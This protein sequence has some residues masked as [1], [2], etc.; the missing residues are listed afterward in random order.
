MLGRW[1]GP[2][3][4]KWRDTSTTG[5]YGEYE[6]KVLIIATHKMGLYA[7]WWGHEGRI[8]NVWVK[9]Q[10]TTLLGIMRFEVVEGLY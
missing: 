8:Q 10:A 2:N 3:C 6:R 1:C 5:D 9:L 7:M 4:A